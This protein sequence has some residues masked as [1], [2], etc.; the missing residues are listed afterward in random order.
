MTSTPLEGAGA[1]AE[2]DDGPTDVPKRP[3]EGLATCSCLVSSGAAF[4]DG[5]GG[6]PPNPPKRPLEGFPSRL[7]LASI[8]AAAAAAAGGGG[9]PPNLPKRPPERAAGRP[10][11]ASMPELPKANEGVLKM[12]LLLRLDSTPEKA[13]EPLLSKVWLSI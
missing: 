11:L 3:P 13:T 2:G 10:S 12:D 7:C 4:A 5:G 8:G 9:G 6:G 1:G